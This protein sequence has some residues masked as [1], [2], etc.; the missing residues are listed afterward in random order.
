M[1]VVMGCWPVLASAGCRCSAD[2]AEPHAVATASPDV[3]HC[4]RGSLQVTLAP[5]GAEPGHPEPDLDPGVELPFSA[6]PGMAVALRD[7]FFATGLRH[8][9]RG[10]VAVLARL[11]AENAP[12][13][14]AELGRVHGD[15]APPR[16]AVDG[17][18]LMVVL[19]E[20]RA[21]GHDLRIGRIAGGA[22][23]AP[24]S[25]R[26]GPR[27]TSSESNTF[28]LAAHAGHVVVVYDDWSASANHGRILSATLTLDEPAQ[29]RVEGKAVS[30]K[31]VDAE[32]PRITARPSGFWLGWLVSPSHAAGATRV[33]DPSR[34]AGEPTGSGS[35]AFGSRWLEITPLDALGQV[36]GDV[37]R[38]TPRDER[39]V[40]YDLTAGPS[41]SAWV[42]WRQDAPTPGASG[43]RIFL[44]ELRGDGSIEVLPVRDEDVGAG[45]P[46]WLWAGTGRAPWLTF[47]DA[48]DRTLLLR[49]EGV[50]P[51][52]APL[53]LG[54]D[55]NGAAAL[56]AA[57]ER[58]L[59]AAPRGRAIELFPA[60]CQAPS[61]GSGTTDAGTLLF[62]EPPPDAS[63]RRDEREQ[64][65]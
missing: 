30:A 53:R 27:Q 43:G 46:N 36:A 8:E 56:A 4:R 12:T 54:A 18:D 17:N 37:R 28:D 35:S 7:E 57:G 29:A 62:A 33:Y 1:L 11:G 48:L 58:V 5:S 21:G 23:D 32:A 60:T 19:Q 50:R 13:Q 52:G 42:V 40:G 3:P 16:L 38:I 61:I 24:P 55:M 31:G 26:D 14:V 49:V 63:V 39:V 6:E 44:A 20:A 59:F 10:S 34:E 45:E 64:K 15:A 2:E 51:L 41:G 65:R 25:W 22:L 47:P 9:A